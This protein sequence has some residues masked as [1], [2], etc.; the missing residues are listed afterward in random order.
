M[1]VAAKQS[2]YR[3]IVLLRRPPSCPNPFTESLR[4]NGIL[5][6]MPPRSIL[7][8]IRALLWSLTVMGMGLLPVY[9][10]YKREMSFGTS[11]RLWAELRYLIVGGLTDRWLNRWL[12]RTLDRTNR[13]SPI[14]LIHGHRCD[15]AM[16]L[17]AAWA[18]QNRVPMICHVHSGMNEANALRRGAW[19]YTE[20]QIA[21]IRR[22]CH[23]LTLSPLLIPKA[24]DA[25]GEPVRASGLP[26][27]IPDRGVRQKDDKANDTCVMATV[28]RLVPRKG[29][30]IF[31]EAM[32]IVAKQAKGATAV[33]IGDGPLM[34]NLQ[35]IAADC[36][37]RVQFT[38]QL[39]PEEVQEFLETEVDV[40]VLAS[41][42]EGLPM[43]IIE[44]M[45]SG[46]PII[47]TPVGAVPD[48]VRDAENGYLVPVGDVSALAEAMYL[49]A[50]DPERRLAMGKA[51]RE[52][53]LAHFSQEAVWPKLEALYQS[54]V[55]EAGART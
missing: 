24:I 35:R 33:V 2:G 41:E 14:T 27:W 8:V 22:H 36:Q 39:T 23:I 11:K 4:T 15:R 50:T 52:R 43:T 20:E 3:V 17:V 1:A 34:E 21:L 44:A 18:E 30:E 12:Y 16:P 48:L 32:G 5:F 45:A 38:G 26:N 7:T 9:V 49:L 31:V 46:L 40:F 13:Q 29:L 6:W 42:D 54:L 47:A 28:S 10:L 53:Y 55:A 19:A 37:V 51:S 25:F